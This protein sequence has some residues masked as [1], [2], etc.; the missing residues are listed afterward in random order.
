MISEYEVKTG[1]PPD[2]RVKY[3]FLS[4]NEV[5]RKSPPL[6]GYRCDWLYSEDDPNP[7]GIWMIWPEFE[8]E[9][10]KPLLR[11]QIASI[12]GTA[13][14]WILSHECR[15]EVHRERIKLGTHG[16][17]VEGSRKIAE[18]EVIEILGL[19]TNENRHPP[20]SMGAS[21]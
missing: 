10:Q 6:Q 13:R 16:Y 7:V 11:E 15:V 8:D 19:M 4:E 21:A 2:F 3:R 14:M 18:A 20:K 12:Q 1:N 17:F 9:H 5:G